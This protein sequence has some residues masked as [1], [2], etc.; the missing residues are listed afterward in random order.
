MVQKMKKSWFATSAVF[1]FLFGVIILTTVA[2]SF[3]YAAETEQTCGTAVSDLQGDRSAAVEEHNSVVTAYGDEID[4]YNAVLADYNAKTDPCYTPSIG[5]V[6]KACILGYINT[7]NDEIGFADTD[8]GH[9]DFDFDLGDLD[10]GSAIS[11]QILSNW[12]SCVSHA[13]NGFCR[14][15]ANTNHL[16]DVMVHI[17]ISSTNLDD[18]CTIL[19]C[20]C[21]ECCM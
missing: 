6:P 11:A 5:C 20:Y 21:Q 16:D 3:V 8:M 15:E 2:V 1:Q 7:S 13:G 18:A 17:G 9:A 10:L 14:Y 19:A 4:R 12:D